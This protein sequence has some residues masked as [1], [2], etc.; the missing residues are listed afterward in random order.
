MYDNDFGYGLLVRGHSALALFL[1]LALPGVQIEAIITVSGNVPVHL[2]TRNAL[3]LLELAKRPDSVVA[4]GSDRPLLRQ[5]V[6]A[7]YIHGQNGIGNVA[8]PEPQ[9]SNTRCFSEEG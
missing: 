6:F 4:G 1:A 8:L 5:P 7:E 2:T 3:A 9:H